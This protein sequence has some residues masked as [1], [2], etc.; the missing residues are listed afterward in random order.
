MFRTD[1]NKKKKHVLHKN[2]QLIPTS[3]DKKKSGS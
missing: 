2:V 1:G 3:E